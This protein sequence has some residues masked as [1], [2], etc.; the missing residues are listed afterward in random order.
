MPGIADRDVRRSAMVDQLPRVLAQDHFV[1]GYVGLCDEIWSSVLERLDDL[2]WFLDVDVAPI[3][4]VQWLG[5]WL[6][7]VVDPTLPHDRQRALVRTAGRTLQWRG[8]RQRVEQLLSALTGAD[9]EVHD[10]GGVFADDEPPRGTQRVVVRLAASGGLSEAQLLDVVRA[11]VP[12]NAT[13]DLSVAAAPVTPPPDDGGDGD[14]VLADPEPFGD[15]G[16]LPPMRGW[17]DRDDDASAPP[18][19]D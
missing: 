6:G 15:E 17:L 8:T 10:G 5:R 14:G 1:R 3:G 7:V 19:G 11:E 18:D 9:V 2:E 4:F 16:F 12:A 13:V